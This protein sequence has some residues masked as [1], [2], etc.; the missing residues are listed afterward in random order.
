VRRDRALVSWIVSQ[1]VIA[2]AHGRV[3]PE[4]ARREPDDI[5][6]ERDLDGGVAGGAVW[7][8]GADGEHTG[9]SVLPGAGGE[10]A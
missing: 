7:P 4:A 9:E 5:G 10:L 8:A 3:R 1:L 6:V 2:Q